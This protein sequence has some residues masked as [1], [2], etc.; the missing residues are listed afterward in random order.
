VLLARLL[1]LSSAFSPLVL[2]LGVR[3]HNTSQSWI[4]ISISIVMAFGLFFAMLRS[5]RFIAPVLISLNSVEDTS[6]EVT[7]YL[8]A[9][10]LPFAVL[11]APT[12]RDLFAFGIFMFLL[13]VAYLQSSKLAVNPWLYFLRLK[14]YS[15]RLLS[16]EVLVISRI[17]P[18][19]EDTIAMYRIN[20]GLYFLPERA[21]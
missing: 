9:Y 13:V 2:V 18:T 12:R 8:A 5:R 21:K 4:L 16:E 15:G 17:R 1:L 20:K 10:I 3:D 14:M 19:E 6:D 11:T 7:G